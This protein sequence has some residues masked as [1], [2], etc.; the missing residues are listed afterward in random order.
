[1]TCLALDAAASVALVMCFPHLNTW[2]LW[3]LLVPFLGA[4]GALLFEDW[5][6][7]IVELLDPL[8]VIRSDTDKALPGKWRDRLRRLCWATALICAAVALWDIVLHPMQDSDPD[9]P[10]FGERADDAPALPDIWD[11]NS[12][13]L[14]RY[15]DNGEAREERELLAL[16]AEALEVDAASD[17]AVQ[18]L[19]PDH[20]LLLFKVANGEHR[21]GLPAHIRWKLA[22]QEP[23]GAWPAV[24]DTSF[25]ST[26]NV[27]LCLQTHAIMEASGQQQEAGEPVLPPEFD[28][29]VGDAPGARGA[30]LAGCG[31]WTHLLDT[32]YGQENSTHA[33]SPL[34]VAP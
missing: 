1:V 12:M 27:T 5:R 10:E 11:Q 33:H 16:A 19:L 21:R 30:Y 24:V 9:M 20:R 4:L 32:Y 7:I 13:M 3:A 22:L 18:R 14:L 8:L 25:P 31:W 6:E 34:P 15:H 26:L 29:V 28:R 17:L 2:H 23:K